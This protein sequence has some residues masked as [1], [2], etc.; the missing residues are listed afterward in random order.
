VNLPRKP[1]KRATSGSSTTP[2][3]PINMNRNARPDVETETKPVARWRK[4]LLTAAILLQLAWMGIL[5]SM[6][7]RK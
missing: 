4:W 1:G 2:E 7:V 3:N 6:A 5:L